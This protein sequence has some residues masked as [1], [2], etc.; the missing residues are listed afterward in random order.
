MI[1]DAKVSLPLNERT[2]RAINLKFKQHKNYSRLEK[3]SKEIQRKKSTINC[4][5][6][7]SL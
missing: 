6:K 2:E 3:K 5:Y 1:N 7:F 4:I